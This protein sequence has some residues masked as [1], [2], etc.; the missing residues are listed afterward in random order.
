MAHLVII[1]YVYKMI[2]TLTLPWFHFNLYPFVECIDS[3]IVEDP[4][5]VRDEFPHHLELR[6]CSNFCSL[7]HPLKIIQNLVVRCSEVGDQ[8]GHLSQ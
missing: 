4:V 8:L 6:L 1:Y 5:R 3:G 2:Y 7:V